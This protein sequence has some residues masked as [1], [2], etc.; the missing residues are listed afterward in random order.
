MLSYLW[1][2]TLVCCRHEGVSCLACNAR[3]TGLLLVVVL[4]AY[5]PR[6]PVAHM[7]ARPNN[8]NKGIMMVGV[9]TCCM[10]CCADLQKH[11]SMR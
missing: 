4:L 7:L 6:W 9:S 3:E 5:S 8:K 1:V 11:T 2:S 10:V